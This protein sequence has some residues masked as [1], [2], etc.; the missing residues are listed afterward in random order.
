[1]TKITPKRHSDEAPQLRTSL[2]RKALVLLVAIFLLLLWVP[3]LYQA[4]AEFKESRSV[5]I[6]H[7][8]TD[9]WRTPQQRAAELRELL[10]A[11]AGEYDGELVWLKALHINRH[12][13]LDSTSAEGEYWLSLRGLSGSDADFEQRRSQALE[14]ASVRSGR[15]ASLYRVGEAFFKYT[16]FSS[17]YLRQWESVTEESSKFALATRPAM[18]W[19]RY[20][21]FRDLG[22]K[23]V[24]ATQGDW[25]F[26][27]TGIDWTI[28][29]PSLEPLPS[30]PLPSIWEFQH[31][32]AQR[33]IQLLVV[34]V[35]N[36]SSVYPD[37][38]SVTGEFRSRALPYLDTLRAQGVAVVDLFAEF[39]QARAQNDTVPLYLAHD[40]HWETRGVKIAAQAVAQQVRQMLPQS[41]STEEY[42]E[43]SCKVERHGDII[44]MTQLEQASFMGWGLEF[45][46]QVVECA[47]VYNLRRDSSGAVVDS[48]LYKDNHRSSEILLLGDSFSRIFQSDAPRSAGLVAHIA[49]ELQMPMASI[50]S[51][52]GASTL[53]R[54]TLA[55]RSGVL[56]GKK[57]VIWEF[58]ERDLRFG[59]EGW[60]KVDL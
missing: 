30:L 34:I 46:P 53:V 45:A 5:Q 4:L 39:A 29:D 50:V 13:L 20:Q 59:A 21:L 48:I 12:H 55:R 44:A 35:P 27:R 51:D 6:A 56:K 28:I 3:P 14:H 8:F 9:F 36:K 42:V 23:G 18:Q 25:S 54:Q 60:L 33:D 58:V 19:W 43:R 52:G 1:M 15:R 7:I 31:Q 57:L 41:Q 37:Y 38:L 24:T 49:K 17:S 47:Q 40:T 11:P 26:Y 22:E 2:S 32:L 16:I 10:S